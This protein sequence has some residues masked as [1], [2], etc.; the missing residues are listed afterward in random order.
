[1]QVHTLLIRNITHAEYI[2]V[3]T[4]Y[5]KEHVAKVNC[6]NKD[7]TLVYGVLLLQSFTFS[8]LAYGAILEELSN[9]R[10]NK[11]IGDEEETK[12]TEPDVLQRQ[13]NKEAKKRRNTSA[14]WQCSPAA[15]ALVQ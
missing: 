14:F 8:V 1:M 7:R 3:R 6:V 9:Q 4:E 15:H 5:R 12:E 11:N 13:P 10:R 2:Q